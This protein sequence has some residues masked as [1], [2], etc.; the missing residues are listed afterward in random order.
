MD[1]DMRDEM[2]RNVGQNV[3][4]EFDMFETLFGVD[5]SFGFDS[6]VGPGSTFDWFWSFVEISVLGERKSK[7][8]LRHQI[9]H[10]AFFLYS[11]IQ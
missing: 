7:T 2:E 1:G 6:C 11:S 9:L 10:G 4:Q 5:F 3:E 8:V